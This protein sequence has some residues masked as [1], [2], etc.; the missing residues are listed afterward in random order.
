MP[1]TKEQK[2]KIYEEERERI[3]ARE[4]IEAERARR[5]QPKFPKIKE[6]IKNW[7]IVLGFFL[8]LY[9]VLGGNN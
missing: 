4:R 1:L 8:M 3:R 9:I 5:N 2:K 7:I 6:R